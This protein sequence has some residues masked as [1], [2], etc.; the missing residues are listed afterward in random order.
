[1][2]ARS[3]ALLG[4]IVRAIWGDRAIA[5]SFPTGSYT[6]ADCA[7]WLS[8]D[9]GAYDCVTAM[10]ADHAAEFVVK[11]RR[12]RP[13]RVARL[14]CLWLAAAPRGAAAARGSRSYTSP[15]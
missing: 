10:T 6:A 7:R 15:R 4:G 9:P 8:N 14:G 13:T 5:T 12:L 2:R 11:R 3:A 1:M